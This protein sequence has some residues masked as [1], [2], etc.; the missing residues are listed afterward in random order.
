MFCCC[1]FELLSAFIESEL[2]D[3]LPTERVQ[4]SCRLVLY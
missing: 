3:E 1:C 2:I 4:P